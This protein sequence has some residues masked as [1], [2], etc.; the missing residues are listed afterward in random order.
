MAN[1]HNNFSKSEGTSI[2]NKVSQIPEYI[3]V[4]IT[5][6]SDPL[7]KHLIFANSKCKLDSHGRKR[8]LLIPASLDLDRPKRPRITFQNWQIEAME[9]EFQSNPFI[10]EERRRLLANTV[11][12][13]ETQV[14]V[15]FQNRRTKVRKMKC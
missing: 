5:T 1:Y 10:T 7:S 3:R 12:I 14:K 4:I 9:Q 8:E 15:W 11:G 6:V 2:S 13:T